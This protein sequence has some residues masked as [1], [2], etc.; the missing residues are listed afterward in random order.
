MPALAVGVFTQAGD[1]THTCQIASLEKHRSII[2]MQNKTGGAELKSQLPT[3]E[4]NGA[5]L[6]I[7]S[8]HVHSSLVLTLPV[9]LQVFELS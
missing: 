5:R 4:L 7:G 2:H 3:F 1:R 6:T 8:L 9:H